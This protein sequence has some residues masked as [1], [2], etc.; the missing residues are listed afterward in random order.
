MDPSGKVTGTFSCVHETAINVPSTVFKSST[1]TQ[2]N[3]PAPR[4][5]YRKLSG[6]LYISLSWDRSHAHFSGM[7]T[8]VDFRLVG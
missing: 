5:L 3:G 4:Y 8:V 6:E 1:S 2:A 7:R